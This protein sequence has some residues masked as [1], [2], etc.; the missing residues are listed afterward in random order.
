MY[1]HDRDHHHGKNQHNPAYP[2]LPPYPIHCLFDGNRVR[3]DGLR[4]LLS[5]HHYFSIG[6]PASFQPLMDG[7]A[8][9]FTFSTPN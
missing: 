4:K 3:S 1:Y 2:A 8:N 6:Y 7:S 9:T 5:T